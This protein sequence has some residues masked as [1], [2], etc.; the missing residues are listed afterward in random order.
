MNLP[1]PGHGAPGA[2]FE[3]PL[4]MLEACHGRVR[5]QCATLRRLP[6]HLAAHGADA[7]ARNAAVAVMRY[8]NTAALDHHADE[9]VDLFPA[10]TDAAAGADA[11]CLRATID[12]LLAEHRMLEGRWQRLR[13]LLADIA[14]GQR[15]TLA[16]TD[17]LP[18]IELY[19][20][21]IAYEEAGLLPMAARLLGDAALDRIGRA[22]RLRRGIE[23]VA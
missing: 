11:V 19:E 6:A 15:G 21:H 10:L 7:Q 2:S 22:M 1:F 8:F 23:R 18:L 12:R 20:R 14:A 4:E 3:V 17:V 13:V 5:H 16:D 9:E